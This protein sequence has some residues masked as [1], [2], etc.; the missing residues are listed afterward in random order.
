M[1]VS[2]HALALERTAGVHFAV[3]VFTNLTQDH[4]DFHARHGG[5]LRGKAHPVFGAERRHARLGETSPP[6]G[7]AV[8]NVDDR[9]WGHGSRGS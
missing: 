1:E 3:A 4:L 8:V 2:S 6:P 7:T 5:V 9:L